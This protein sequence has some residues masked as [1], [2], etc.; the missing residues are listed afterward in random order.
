MSIAFDFSI[1]KI[2]LLYIFHSFFNFGLQPSTNPQRVRQNLQSL[3]MM[4]GLVRFNKWIQH[5]KTL[6]SFKR[7]IHSLISKVNAINENNYTYK[8]NYSYNNYGYNYTYNLL[9]TMA[10]TIP[11]NKTM[12]EK[13]IFDDQLASYIN[14]NHIHIPT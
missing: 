7:R 4:L 13:M 2:R 9:L 11:I 12:N 5:W 6:G 1:F 8:Q 3:P 14:I 10:I